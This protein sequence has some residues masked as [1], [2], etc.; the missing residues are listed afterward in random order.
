MKTD[1]VLDSFAIL[2]FLN[3]EPGHE[4]VKQLLRQAS[5]HHI[6]LYINQ[7]N[8]GECFYIIHRARSA[9]TAEDFLVTLQTLPIEVIG[10]N[11]QD[12]IEAARIKAQYPLSYADAFV[13]A[14]A[15]KL[16][17]PVLTGDPEFKQVEH[18]ANIRWL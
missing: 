8:V 12:V 1:A 4:T 5:N 3:R 18:L 11:F 7:I 13:I 17:F 16:E 10:N 2:T 14:T 9:K 6:K 15:I